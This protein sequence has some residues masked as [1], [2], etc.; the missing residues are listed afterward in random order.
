MHGELARCEPKKLRYRP[1]RY[2]LAAAFSRL[3]AL[4]SRCAPDPQHIAVR[5]TTREPGA[6]GTSTPAP[7]AR[8]PNQMPD[9]NPTNKTINSALRPLLKDRG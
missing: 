2:E 5:P 6:A 3:A 9:G 7:F 4:R 1:W 8:P